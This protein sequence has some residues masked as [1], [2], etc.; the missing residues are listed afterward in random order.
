MDGGGG[1]GSG[2]VGGSW[3]VRMYM[4]DVW[5][6]RKGWDKGQSTITC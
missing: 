2:G 5:A 3:V 4:M 1:G 6:V